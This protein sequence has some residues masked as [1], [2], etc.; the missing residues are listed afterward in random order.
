MYFYSETIVRNILLT[1]TLMSIVLGWL[2][3]N[4]SCLCANASSTISI[5]QKLENLESSC[6]LICKELRNCSCCTIDE[7]QVVSISNNMNAIRCQCAFHSNGLPGSKLLISEIADSCNLKPQLFNGANGLSL[8]TNFNQVLS[9]KINNCSFKI[10]DSISLLVI[11]CKL[12][13]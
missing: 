6:C 12:N 2:S 4:I 11:Y 3:P 1:F 5:N 10:K 13:I 7:D 8:N 9:R